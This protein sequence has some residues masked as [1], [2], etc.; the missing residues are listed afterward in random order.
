MFENPINYFI[1]DQAIRLD[2]KFLVG[3]KTDNLLGKQADF[4]D[5]SQQK[6]GAFTVRKFYFPIS[7]NGDDRRIPGDFRP[8]FR[9][10]KLDRGT[11]R[12]K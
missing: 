11:F 6:R 4:L 10:G 7:R 9:L 5:T 2:E 1:A 8:D 3:N 12:R